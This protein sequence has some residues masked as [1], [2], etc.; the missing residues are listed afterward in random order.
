[1]NTK[2][3]GLDTD[4]RHEHQRNMVLLLTLEMNIKEIFYDLDNDLGLEMNTR[5]IN[6]ILILTQVVMNTRQMSS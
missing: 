4:L 5:E 1:M 2:E 3:Y 6:M